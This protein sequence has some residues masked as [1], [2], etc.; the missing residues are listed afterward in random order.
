MEA[1]Y[2]HKRNQM[3]KFYEAVKSAQEVAIDDIPLPAAPTD[4][5]STAFNLSVFPTETPNPLSIL[6]RPNSSLTQLRHKTPP[7]VPP[8]PPPVL[9]DVEDDFEEEESE[10][11]KEKNKRI[12][13]SDETI[14]KDSDVNEFLKEIELME[15]SVN[16]P[17]EGFPQTIHS[18]QSLPAL[19]SH[20]S[21]SSVPSHTQLPQ[22]IRPKS[23]TSG[24]P[25]PQMMMFRA[26]PPPSNIR[27]SGHPN[28]PGMI[29]GR[30]GMPPGPPNVLRPGLPP[31]RIL[32][33]RP[34]M[35]PMRPMLGPTVSSNAG[36]TLPK[37]GD[38]KTHFVTDRATIEAKPQLR[39]L[40]ADATRFTPVALR[41]K[42]EEKGTKKSNQK[43][44]NF[45]KLSLNWLS[46]KFCFI[47][48][49]TEFKRYTNSNQSSG[50]NAPTKDD[51][52]DQFMKEMQNLI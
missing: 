27:S 30:P 5:N 32:G 43:F 7:G 36:S 11:E 18:I 2:E 38:K 35:P 22:S 46:I 16:I 17:N 21:S 25:P 39:N 10:D 20:Q 37:S 28:V 44:G 4:S 24:A 29:V 34:M 8:G 13:F 19:S 52:Y 23:L 40:S 41:V 12:R 33:P 31:H 51:A 1:D 49:D 15:K 6:K 14:E 45:C 50:L 47:G 9:S 3:I 42:R 26:V 48:F